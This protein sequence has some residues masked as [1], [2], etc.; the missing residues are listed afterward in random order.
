MQAQEMNLGLYLRVCWQML[1][2]L[3]QIL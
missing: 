3:L 2:S 1:T